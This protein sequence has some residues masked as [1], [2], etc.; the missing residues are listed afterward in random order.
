MINF[1]NQ[2]FKSEKDRNA[3]AFK[4]KDDLII[5]CNQKK[6]SHVF[7][8]VCFGVLLMSFFV[9]EGSWWVFIFPFVIPVLLCYLISLNIKKTEEYAHLHEQFL[10]KTERFVK[11]I[12]H[13]FH[14]RYF[15]YDQKIEHISDLVNFINHKKRLNLNEEEGV[16]LLIQHEKEQNIELFDEEISKLKDKSV[17]NIAKTLIK[18]SPEINF[19]D[20]EDYQSV[21]EQ[22]EEYLDRKNIEYGTEELKQELSSEFK[23][24]KAIHF[25]EKLSRDLDKK[26]S[27][28]E[29][30]HLNGFEFEELLGKLFRKA[31]YKVQITKKSGDQGADL[32]IEKDGVSTAIQ[33]KKYAGNVGNTAVQEIVA[34]MKYYDCDKSMVITTGKFTK[35]AFE[36][37]GKNGVQLIDKKGLDDLFDSIL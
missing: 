34:A 7:W 15:T 1:L 37:A 29:I 36:L 2:N 30:E 28:D 32:I 4:N 35:G 16:F 6:S 9:E 26:I 23:S 18:L 5:K 3:Y 33:A 21:L 22:L 20:E 11:D 13:T 10:I 25:E 31:G 8:G 27:I 24:I 19:E 14:E 12:L 17:N